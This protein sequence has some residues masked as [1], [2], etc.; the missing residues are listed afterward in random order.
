M[1]ISPAPVLQTVVACSF[2]VEVRLSWG[3]SNG[4]GREP[5]LVSRLYII[6]EISFPWPC[7]L[8]YLFVC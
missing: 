5:T 1:L 2:T 3:R 6:L 7:F 8:F 4:S